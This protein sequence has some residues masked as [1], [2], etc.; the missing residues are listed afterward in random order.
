MPFRYGGAVSCINLPEA[1]KQQLIDSAVRLTKAFGLVGLNSLDTIV[2]EDKVYVLEINPRLSATFELY[3]HTE[4]SLLSLHVQASL[5]QL[6]HVSHFKQLVTLSKAHAIVY[7]PFDMMIPA[8]FD[9][10]DWAVDTPYDGN[11]VMTVEAPVCSVLAEAADADT[12]KQLA[13]TR[14]KMLLNLLKEKS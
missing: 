1:I 6:E 8:G 2:Q 9:W 12:A 7:A 3:E 5:G 14:V 10:P 11:Q 4:S 13:Q